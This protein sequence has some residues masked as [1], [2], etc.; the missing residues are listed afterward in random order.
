MLPACICKAPRDSQLTAS[1]SLPGLSPQPKHPT[2]YYQV[3]VHLASQVV[4]N[5]SSSS[6]PAEEVAS[7]IQQSGGDAITVQADISK[8]DDVQ[9]WALCM[10]RCPVVRCTCHSAVNASDCGLSLPA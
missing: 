8:P 6:G 5:F 10:G 4:V 7:A 2:R 9:R 3:A 1:C